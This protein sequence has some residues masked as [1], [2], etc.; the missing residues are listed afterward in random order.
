MTST[1][2]RL[3]SGANASYTPR[4]RDFVI[5][6]GSQTRYNG[7]SMRITSVSRDGQRLNLE[8]AG[9]RLTNVRLAS[10][11]SDMPVGA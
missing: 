7:W 4:V 3:T 8:E 10:V 9:T 11:R 1:T 5:Y 2:S 6:Q